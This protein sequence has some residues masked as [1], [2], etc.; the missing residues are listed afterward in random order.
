MSVNRATFIQPYTNSFFTTNNE[1]FSTTVFSPIESAFC[2]TFD[3]TNC[4]AYLTTKQF[5]KYF[6]YFTTDC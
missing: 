6:S 3:E 5:S 2:E 1:T 4:A